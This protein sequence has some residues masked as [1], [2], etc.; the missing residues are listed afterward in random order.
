[1][2]L[3]IVLVPC[4]LLEPSY[5][6]HQCGFVQ[7]FAYWHAWKDSNLPGPTYP[8][9]ISVKLTYYNFNSEIKNALHLFSEFFTKSG[10]VL[11]CLVEKHREHRPPLGIVVRMNA[12]FQGVPL[13]EQDALLPASADGGIEPA[14]VGYK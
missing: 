11:A 13:T 10:K 14:A 3:R 1:M 6:L 8:K 9:P 7:C 2:T 5:R 12:L 4:L